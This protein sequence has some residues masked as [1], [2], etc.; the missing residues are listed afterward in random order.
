MIW[1][2]VL[3]EGEVLKFIGNVYLMALINAA[4]HFRA[5]CR[6]TKAFIE[7]P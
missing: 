5:V 6:R 3:I 2:F 1:H 4:S 7:T